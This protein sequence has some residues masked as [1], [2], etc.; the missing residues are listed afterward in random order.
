MLET[1]AEGNNRLA[2]PRG[3]GGALNVPRLSVPSCSGAIDGPA[4][5]D[6]RRGRDVWR[7]EWALCFLATSAGRSGMM[8]LL[9]TSERRAE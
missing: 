1:S 9:S 3:V 8:R 5:G 7:G 2:P 6:E 4:S